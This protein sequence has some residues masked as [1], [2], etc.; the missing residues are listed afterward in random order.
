MTKPTLQ[1]ALNDYGLDAYLITVGDD[2]PHTSSVTVE[3]D[4]ETI[5][6]ALGKSAQKNVVAHP[7][8]SL[9]WPPR[10]AGGYGII[11]NG[12]AGIERERDGFADARIALTK[13]VFHRPGPKPENGTGPCQSDCIALSRV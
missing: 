5:S 12:R 10:E 9:F 4:G 1:S 13:S 6:C 2:G 8:V 7:D 3:L 11:L